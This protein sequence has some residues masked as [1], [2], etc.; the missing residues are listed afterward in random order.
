M[1]TN[2][3]INKIKQFFCSHK[4]ITVDFSCRLS[5]FSSFT[6][7]IAKCDSCQKRVDA[8]RESIEMSA[9]IDQQISLKRLRSMQQLQPR[10][11]YENN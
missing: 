4:N 9:Y 5:P 10:T 1:K 11:S 2:E 8:P 6:V 7:P 3:L